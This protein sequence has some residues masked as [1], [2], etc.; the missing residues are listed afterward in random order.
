MSYLVKRLVA[1]VFISM[2]NACVAYPYYP[3]SG[4]Y[5]IGY[6]GNHGYGGGGG[7]YYRGGYHG[8]GQRPFGGHRHWR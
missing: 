1:L 8:Y 6:Y 2:L 4:G 3:Y 5:S 7:G